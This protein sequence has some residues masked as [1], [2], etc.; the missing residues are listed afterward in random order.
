MDFANP[1]IVLSTGQ[2]CVGPQFDE[3]VEKELALSYTLAQEVLPED[4]RGALLE[5][6]LNASEPSA[7]YRDNRDLPTNTMT[8]LKG[9]L[10]VLSS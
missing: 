9:T 2:I 7:I 8:H 4:L 1:K 6:G 5:Q 10:G 3:E